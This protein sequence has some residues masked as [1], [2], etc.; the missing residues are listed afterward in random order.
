[1]ELHSVI[2]VQFVVRKRGGRVGGLSV[3]SG[4]G[5]GGGKGE[6]TVTAANPI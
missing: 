5:S 1:M 4:G 3:C 6:P 2:F